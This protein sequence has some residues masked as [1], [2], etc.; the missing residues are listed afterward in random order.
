MRPGKEPQVLVETTEDTGIP[1]T[2]FGDNVAFQ[3]GAGDTQRLALASR[4]DG[5]V[6]RR[7]STRSDTGLTASP[8]GKTLYYCFSGAIWAQAVAGGDP[9]RLT[10]GID[11]TV[12]SSGQYLFVKRA[13][14]GVMELIRLPAAGGEAELLPI[15][16]EYHIANPGLS[17]A[18]VDA[19]GR[20]LVSVISNHSFYYQT[21]I[22]DPA[23]KS[24][25]LAP[26]AIDGDAS[27]AGWTP[28][29]RILALGERYLFSLWRYQRS[30]ASR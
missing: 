1:A 15:P 24:F 16:S 23:S 11:V 26:T 27:R 13:H 21:A 9:K 29:G 2:T 20:V 3:I 8:D 28:D 25:T 17:P 18:A 14:K 30:K 12:D 4:R 19:R 6:I 10:E 7:Y 22:L 5:R